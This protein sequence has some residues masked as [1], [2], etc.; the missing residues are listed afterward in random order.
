[1]QSFIHAEAPGIIANSGYNERMQEEFWKDIYWLINNSDAL[2]PY[3]MHTH[4]Y[5]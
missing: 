3:G 1:M 5:M 4:T 2:F